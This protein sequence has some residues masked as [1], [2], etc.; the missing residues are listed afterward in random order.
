L[1]TKT[2]SGAGQG[3]LGRIWGATRT[4]LT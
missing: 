3:P 4:L 2:A 1:Y